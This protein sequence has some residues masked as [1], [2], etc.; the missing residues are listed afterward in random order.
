VSTRRKIAATI[1]FGSS[2]VAATAY[3]VLAVQV[4]NEIHDQPLRKIS[5][6]WTARKLAKTFDPDNADW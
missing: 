3:S 1:L 2:I 6:A 5:A 4:L